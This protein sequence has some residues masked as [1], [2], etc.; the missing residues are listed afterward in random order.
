MTPSRTLDA[1]KSM[2][3]ALCVAC[4][5]LFSATTSK[6]SD[7]LLRDA[8]QSDQSFQELGVMLQGVT[9]EMELSNVFDAE[10][11]SH[12][13]KM[14]GN[15][16]TLR[17]QG[18]Q[19]ILHALEKSFVGP[20]V[21]TNYLKQA[22]DGHRDV[23]NKL[24]RLATL[25]GA[26]TAD[27]AQQEILDKLRELAAN[28]E[29]L[30]S[31]VS[32]GHPL[33]SD[34]KEISERYGDQAKSLAHEVKY[35][36]VMRHLESAGDDLFAK[37]PVDAKKELDAAIRE[38]K[39][40]LATAS[41]SLASA[42]EM[43]Q[44]LQKLADDLAKAVTNTEE[45]AKTTDPN[46]AQDR[47]MD[48]L[49]KQNDIK[50]RLDAANQKDASKEVAKAMDDTQA[51][52]FDP[53]AAK[54]DA[55]R[56]AVTNEAQALANQLARASQEQLNAFK[57]MQQMAQQLQNIEALQSKL[58]AIRAEQAQLT[59]NVAPDAQQQSAK[60]QVLAQAMSQLAGDMQQ[61]NQQNTAMTGQPQQP[62][63]QAAQDTS[64]AAQ[65]T[66]NN[67]PAQASQQLAQASQ[68]LAQAEAQAAQQLAQAEQKVE[69]GQ[70]VAD[71]QALTQMQSQ[72]NQMQ[73]QY[74][75]ASPQGKQAMASQM[76]NM[77]H[78]M[79]QAALPDAAHQMQ[80]AQQDA[81][82]N[83]APAAGQD[84]QAAQQALSQAIQQAQLA[85]QAMQHSGQPGQQTAQQ[86]QGQPGQGEPQSPPSSDAESQVT[87]PG[88][89]GMANN[90]KLTSK[91]EFAADM[92]I[93]KAHYSDDANWHATLPERERQAL[94]S[95]RKEPY[96]PQME[97]DIKKYYEL[98]AE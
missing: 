3:L 25:L 90:P 68:Q 28:V 23:A 96:P 40:K 80:Q 17:E 97:E 92:A 91:R 88:Q 2:M 95:A 47:M 73:Q 22:G 1:Q 81:Q 72:L 29:P 39:D 89:A 18:M 31:Q 7:D 49:V 54:L 41:D 58:D 6:A 70:T 78:Q 74:A 69:A 43:E 98:L 63:A 11:V 34:Q 51:S 12:G 9:H 48:A 77:A 8:E 59:N 42:K 4:A 46:K 44:N 38:L 21:V 60:Q 82:K 61:A 30:A 36:S 93:S 19:P 33:K 35:E 62:L 94:L 52:K 56:T 15:V 79:D 86:G 24:T 65:S 76:A 27:A 55:A 87:Q 57:E 32:G 14:A 67:K 50:D 75:Q 83:N 85:A 64:A 10:E 84:M 13:R 16:I 5:C 20:S 66:D 45:I 53:A 71:A 37:D 26:A